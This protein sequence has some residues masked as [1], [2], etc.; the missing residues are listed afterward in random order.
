MTIDQ[1]IENHID[2][3]P[4]LLRKLDREAHVKLLRPRMNSGHLQG[5]TLKM[6][7][8]MIRPTRILEIGTFAGYSA[9]CFAEGIGDEG[10]V[11]TIDI[12]DELETFARKYFEL[13][14]YGNRIHYHIGDA[15]EIIPTID[16]TF[17]LVFIDADKRSYIDYYKMV[18]PRVKTGGVIIADNTLWDGKVVEPL[19]A[20]DHQ[21]E[22][23][24]N[25][26]RL[27]AEDER[28]EK[29]I[30]PVRDGLTILWKK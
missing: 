4:E 27:I 17:D 13:S 10:I 18:L 25:F 5:R 7:T 14:P 21:T 26:N 6:L 22:G 2:V 16:E 24:L 29:V 30:L 19:V 8:R 15:L 3:E 12:D 11:H 20:N 23:I 1:Y 9:L 28:V